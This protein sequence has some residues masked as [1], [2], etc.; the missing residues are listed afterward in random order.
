MHKCAS[1]SAHAP[2][3]AVEVAE[4][5]AVLLDRLELRCAGMSEAPM[6]RSCRVTH[7][8]AGLQDFDEAADLVGDLG[9]RRAELGRAGDLRTWALDCPIICG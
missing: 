3:D 4:D 6:H 8:E 9:A 7:L 5:L 1:R 2:V